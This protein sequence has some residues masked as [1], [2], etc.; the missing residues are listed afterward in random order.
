MKYIDILNIRAIVLRSHRSNPNKILSP[1]TWDPLRKCQKMNVWLR[2]AGGFDSCL[3][4]SI[5]PLV[6]LF[7]VCKVVFWAH[8]R[9]QSVKNNMLLIYGL[10]QSN[11]CW[12]YLFNE[13]VSLNRWLRKILSIVE[14]TFTYRDAL[15]CDCNASQRFPHIVVDHRFSIV[16]MYTCEYI[17][18]VIACLSLFIKKLIFLLKR[19]ALL[20]SNLWCVLQKRSLIWHSIN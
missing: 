10:N 16:W 19:N 20:L 8:M 12:K 5:G 13:H 17:F 7:R 1:N 6:I 15:G 14:T 3:K 4:F 18:T 2:G 9:V 11:F